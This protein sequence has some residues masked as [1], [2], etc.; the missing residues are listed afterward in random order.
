MSAIFDRLRKNWER[1][2]AQAKRLNVEACRFYDRDIPEYPYVA[3]I[4]KDVVVVQD[5][6]QDIDFA[7]TRLNHHKDFLRSLKDAVNPRDVVVKVRRPQREDGQKDLQY[8]KLGQRGERFSLSEGDV[9]F[10]VNVYDYQDCGLFLDHRRLRYEVS[11]LLEPGQRFLNL[12]SYTGSFSV[13]AALRG[14]TTCS[15]DLSHTYSNWA[16]DNFLLNK[17]DLKKHQFIEESVEKYLNEINERLWNVIVLDPPTFSNSKRT[18]RDFDVQRDH[19]EYIEKCMSILAPDGLLFFSTNM[20]D[21][22]LDKE[23]ASKWHA[24]DMSKET[25][26]FDFSGR[27]LRKVFTFSR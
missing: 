14:A 22:K 5:R 8:Q 24:R 23:I 16:R 1:I 27:R 25:M 2:S 21:F 18:E 20:R 11:R 13:Y 17:L 9:R 4:Y 3:E 7:E 19:V 12:F 26:P 15:V 10:W 6:R